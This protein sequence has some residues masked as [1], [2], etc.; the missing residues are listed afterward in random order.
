MTTPYDAEITNMKAGKPSYLKSTR[1]LLLFANQEGYL[2]AVDD[3]ARLL[4]TAE[5]VE[6]RLR[7][8]TDSIGVDQCVEL[9]WAN[10]LHAAI[11]QAKVTTLDE[12][13][14]GDA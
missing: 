11:K 5:Y 13:G 1:L 14:E 9:D 8:V 12:V 7:E 3:Y 6:S 4:A 10:E 2:R